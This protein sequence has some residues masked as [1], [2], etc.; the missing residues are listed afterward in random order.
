MDNLWQP[1]RADRRKLRDLL[2]EPGW[3]V[4]HQLVV[5]LLQEYNSRV[6]SSKDLL[7]VGRGQGA[8]EALT[9]YHNMILEEVKKEDTD[10]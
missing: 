2:E 1:D 7:E 9:R 3:T 4:A 5:S 6:L 10:E 8:F